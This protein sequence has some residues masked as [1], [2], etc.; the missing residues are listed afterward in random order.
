MIVLRRLLLSHTVHRSK[1]PDQITAVNGHD[2]TRGENLRER[3][4]S[5]PVVGPIEDRDEHNFIRDI[6]IGV[7]G[8]QPPA[9]EDDRLRHGKFDNVQLSSVLIAGRL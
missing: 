3:I 7:T 9:F 2:L 4:E 1:S 8:G 5:D 6:E